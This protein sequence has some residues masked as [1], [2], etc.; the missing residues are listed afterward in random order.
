MIAF[1]TRNSQHAITHV[2]V[3]IPYSNRAP[4][5]LGVK[6]WIQ[7]PDTYMYVARVSMHSSIAFLAYT[8]KIFVAAV[9]HNFL[10]LTPDLITKRVR[11]K[12]RN[13]KW[14][15]KFGEKSWGWKCRTGKCRTECG[16]T[17]PVVYVQSAWTVIICQCIFL[18]S[19][20]LTFFPTHPNDGVISLCITA[21][22]IAT[23]NWSSSDNN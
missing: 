10:S 2:C 15:T 6:I 5:L 19:C 9:T 11:W 18:L 14:K 1:A 7:C 16:P 8:Q 21:H 17:F 20:F 3:L 22:L 12:W 13:E 4:E 23:V